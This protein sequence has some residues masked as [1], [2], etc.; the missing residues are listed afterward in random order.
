MMLC[1]YI[2]VKLKFSS[3]ILFIIEKL[4]ELINIYLLIYIHTSF[5]LY[6]VPY[7]VHVP[8]PVPYYYYNI[9][10]RWILTILFFFFFFFFFFFLVEVMG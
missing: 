5:I 2:N 8:V 6:Q 7:L 1:I 3:V 9:S 10:M 4:N